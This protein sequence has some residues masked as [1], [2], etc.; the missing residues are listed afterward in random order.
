SE[1]LLFS[2][3][4][5]WLV[6]PQNGEVWDLRDALK[7][8]Q[9]DPYSARARQAKFSPDGRYLVMSGQRPSQYSKP[10]ADVLTDFRV[11]E[12]GGWQQIAPAITVTGALLRLEI[13]ADG[14]RFMAPVAKL[15]LSRP[16]S[17]EVS[18]CDPQGETFIFNLTNCQ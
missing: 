2:P 5:R 18:G 17:G 9:L 12:T 15:K 4:G 6:E 11:Y 3:D 7:M 10:G 13:S 1:S 14:Q 16:W 8:Y